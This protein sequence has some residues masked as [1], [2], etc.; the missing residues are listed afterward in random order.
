MNAALEEG[1]G[2][3]LAG[4]YRVEA[5]GADQPRLLRRLGE[6]PGRIV[7]LRMLQNSG[8]REPHR[9]VLPL[10]VTLCRPRCMVAD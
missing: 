2:L 3:V 9:A 5:E 6:T 1:D 4:P 7:A 10:W 8:R